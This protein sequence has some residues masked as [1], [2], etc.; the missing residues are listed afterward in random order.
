[1]IREFREFINRGNIV[2]LAVAF[3]VGITFASVIGVLT[4]RIINPLIALVLPGL[5]RLDALGTFAENGSVGAF[6]GALVNFVVVAFVLFLVVKA[7]NR[8]RLPEPEAE[9]ALAEE[10]LLLREIRDSLRTT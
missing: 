2:E 9:E 3:V 6:I 8:P 4:E 5:D 7:Y 10:V 1:M